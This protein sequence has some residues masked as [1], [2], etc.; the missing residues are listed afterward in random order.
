M[1]K[2]ITK[3]AMLFL[4][5]VFSGNF[6]WAEDANDP[7]EGC[8]SMAIP[9]EEIISGKKVSMPDD[10]LDRVKETMKDIEQE[11]AKLMIEYN[12]ADKLSKKAAKKIKKR[13]IK[14]KFINKKKIKLRAK[15]DVQ[16]DYFLEITVCPLE[17]AKPPEVTAVPP[18][19][20]IET[21]GVAVVPPGE[22]VEP[23]GVAAVPSEEAA[24]PPEEE[25]KPPE[26][27]A[28]PSE[29]AAEPS[30]EVAEA[31]E[32]PIGPKG[33]H[34][35]ISDMGI[36][37]GYIKNR[38][39]L[40]SFI[41]QLSIGLRLPRWVPKEM[42][43]GLDVGYYGGSDS[44]EESFQYSAD[45]YNEDYSLKVIPIILSAYWEIKQLVVRLPHIGLLTPFAGAGLGPYLSKFDY[46]FKIPDYTKKSGGG[47]DGSF[48][49]QTAAGAFTRYKSWEFSLDLKYSYA[50]H[51]SGDGVE[52]KIGGFSI[53]AGA[54]Y[55]YGFSL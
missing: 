29:E 5:L 41:P 26:K 6:A 34:E 45:K 24:K 50:A 8:P 54:S 11:Q 53:N 39:Y 40:S 52:G 15:K 38:D 27:E 19:E 37:L 42:F 21:P 16:E 35:F 55:I 48:G 22:G 4:L 30:E 23:P 25:A 7:E 51:N 9:K 28:E 1:M 32:E 3:I 44:G 17:G 13:M 43:F 20:G 33:P 10:L 46:D 49:L 36:T 31:P 18:G 2:L 47:W 14:E 12:F